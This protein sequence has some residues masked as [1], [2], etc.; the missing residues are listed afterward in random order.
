MMEW[1]RFVPRWPWLATIVAAVLVALLALP[2]IT[3]FRAQNNLERKDTK[4]D[5]L[6]NEIKQLRDEN[7]DLYLLIQ[8]LL[9]ANNREEQQEALDRSAARRRQSDGPS[10]RRTNPTLPPTTNEPNEPEEPP[11][12]T[13]PQIT[14]PRIP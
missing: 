3:A 9:T 11:L 13:I 1:K 5:Q 14:I 6:G 8:D 7:N 2:I 10:Q 12:I 4:I